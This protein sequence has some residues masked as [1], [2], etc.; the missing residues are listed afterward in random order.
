MTQWESH[1]GGHLGSFSLAL[2]LHWDQKCNFCILFWF[3]C[4]VNE[5]QSRPKREFKPKPRQSFD[6]GDEEHSNGGYAAGPVSPPAYTPGKTTFVYF[7]LSLWVRANPP[8]LRKTRCTSAS[9]FW[10]NYFPFCNIKQPKHSIHLHP[11]KDP[12]SR[13]NRVSGQKKITY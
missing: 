10:Q 12:P 5:A 9:P 2:Y 13:A 6:Y 7:A 8:H 1:R 3:S 4:R 11:S